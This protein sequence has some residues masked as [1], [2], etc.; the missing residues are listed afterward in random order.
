MD[1]MGCEELTKSH[2]RVTKFKFRPGGNSG[3]GGFLEC[4]GELRGVASGCGGCERSRGAAKTSLSV[5]GI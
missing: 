2:F 1:S 3:F 4:F 5:G